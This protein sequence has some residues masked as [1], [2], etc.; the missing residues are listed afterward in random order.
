MENELMPLFNPN[1]L[2]L[3]ITST[4]ISCQIVTMLLILLM[5]Y[6]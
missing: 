6:Q 5:D 2:K 1:S 3:D 4:C